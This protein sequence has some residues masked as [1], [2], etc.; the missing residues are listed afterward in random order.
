MK[1]SN[2][3]EQTSTYGGITKHILTKS[4]SLKERWIFLE[5]L[6]EMSSG[7]ITRYDDIVL[8]HT[9]LLFFSRCVR[10][11]YVVLRR[12]VILVC[13]K[14]TWPLILNPRLDYCNMISR[15]RMER[16]SLVLCISYFTLWLQNSPVVTPKGKPSICQ[17]EDGLCL[18]TFQQRTA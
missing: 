7:K 17:H 2:A 15:K 12:C 4:E 14:M 1:W 13:Q 10:F 11:L 3:H 16:I 18:S 6:E 8:K 5:T 9:S